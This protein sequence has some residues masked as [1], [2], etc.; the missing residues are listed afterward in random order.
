M[1]PKEKESVDS[2]PLKKERMS[3]SVADQGSPLIL[4]TVVLA[5]VLAKKSCAI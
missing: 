4:T 1:S 5:D 3:L 2:A